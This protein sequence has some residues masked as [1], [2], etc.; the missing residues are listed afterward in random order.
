MSFKR[1]FVWLATAFVAA[2]SFLLLSIDLSDDSGADEGIV[3]TEPTYAAPRPLPDP[4]SYPVLDQPQIMP[5]IMPQLLPIELR[6]ALE[7]GWPLTLTYHEA[8]ADP[9]YYLAW[10]QAK[11]PGKRFKALL[12][13]V[14]GYCPCPICCGAGAHGVTRTGVHT[15]VEPYGIAGPEALLRRGVHIPGYMFE[16]EPG[17]VWKTDDTGSAL[18]DDWDKHVYHF[19][20]RFQ[21]H[22]WARNWWGFRT[23]VVYL[24]E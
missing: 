16:T 23:M 7:P 4:V 20:V 17:K 18:N 3:V 19:D 1:A 11:N 24:T 9:A 21:S 6:P 2:G 5:Q 13:T 10:L 8:K 14:T 22:Y 12:A 15:S